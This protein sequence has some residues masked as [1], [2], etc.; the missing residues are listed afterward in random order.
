MVQIQVSKWFRNQSGDPSG[1]FLKGP[2][3]FESGDWA[4]GGRHSFSARLYQGVNSF[5]SCERLRVDEVGIGWNSR[6]EKTCSWGQLTCEKDR[7]LFHDRISNHPFL[8]SNPIFYQVSIFFWSPSQ[9]HGCCRSIPRELGCS[10]PKS[11]KQALAL[12]ARCCAS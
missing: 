10:H 4:V 5:A 1:G 6:L 9:S 3:C 8:R 12:S 7:Y 11:S 2:R